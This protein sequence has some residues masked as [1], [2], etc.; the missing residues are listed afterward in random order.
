M[1]ISFIVTAFNRPQLLLC[2]LASLQA[3]TCRD[4][5]IIVVDNAIDPDMKQ[6]NYR[7]CIVTNTED[8]RTVY[9]PTSGPTCYH[10]TELGVALSVGDFVC[11]PSDDSYYVPK[12]VEKIVNA[13]DTNSDLELLYFDLVYEHVHTHQYE[14]MKVRPALYWIDKTGFVLRKDKFVPFPNKPIIDEPAPCDGLLINQLVAT[15]IKHGKV[16]EILGV[17]N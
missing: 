12:F 11:F 7:A 17:H 15:G 13:I 8:I 9:M 2:A 10:S 14:H 3:Q 4:F 5:E 1:K 16:Y 6:A